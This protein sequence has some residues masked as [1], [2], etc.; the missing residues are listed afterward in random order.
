MVKN[1]KHIARPEIM[2]GAAKVGGCVPGIYI[3][4]L[5]DGN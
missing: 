5:V 1:R 2:E 3:V 4:C